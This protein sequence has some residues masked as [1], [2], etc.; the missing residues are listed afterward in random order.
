M[1]ADLGHLL[2]RL[3]IG[4]RDQKDPKKVPA[5][6]FHGSRWR[7]LRVPPIVTLAVETGGTEVGNGR[8]ADWSDGPSCI[9]TSGA[10][11]IS[12][13]EAQS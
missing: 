13:V 10:V 8:W 3:M 5:E 11:V 7:Q 12:V 6:L 1:L 9:V 4:V 2:K